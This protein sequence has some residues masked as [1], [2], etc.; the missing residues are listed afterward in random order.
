MSTVAALRRVT[1]GQLRNIRGNFT[2]NEQLRLIESASKDG[3]RVGWR[4]FLEGKFVCMSK[5]HKRLRDKQEARI[6]AASC[7]LCLRCTHSSLLLV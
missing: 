7:C 4:D 3:G 6:T 1:D 5:P 2:K